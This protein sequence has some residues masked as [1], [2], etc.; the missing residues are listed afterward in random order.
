MQFCFSFNYYDSK[1]T[2]IQHD[3]FAVADLLEGPGGPGTPLFLDQTEA[4]TAEK[5]FWGPARP[6]PPTPYLKVC[7]RH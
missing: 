1:T 4:G 5:F 7:F 2:A 6:L 3:A